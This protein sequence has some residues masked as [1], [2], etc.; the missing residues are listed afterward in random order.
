MPQRHSTLKSGEF[1]PNKNLLC[2]FRALTTFPSVLGSKSRN[3]AVPFLRLVSENPFALDDARFPKLYSTFTA[4][5]WKMEKRTRSCRWQHQTPALGTFLLTVPSIHV[6]GR[7]HNLV[8][9]DPFGSPTYN[10]KA[11]LRMRGVPRGWHCAQSKRLPQSPDTLNRAAVVRADV[12][13]SGAL[14]GTSPR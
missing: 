10:K 6:L 13:F 7:T 2:D 8:V 9:I 12:S 1:L 14:L 3:Q 11:T 5:W 4:K